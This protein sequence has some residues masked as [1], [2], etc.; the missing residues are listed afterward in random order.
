M[1]AVIALG[2]VLLG[3]FATW[4]VSTRVERRRERVQLGGVLGLL[5][6]ELAANSD[7][8][9]RGDD[10]TYGDWHAS[11]AA[12]SQLMRDEEL[13]RRVVKAYGTIFE[14]ARG[15]TPPPP[16]EE[17]DELAQVLAARRDRLLRRLRVVRLPPA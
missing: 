14:A 10:L 6:E 11:K 17:L 13:W 7:R 8:I 4:W 16:A 9:R 15:S 12:F 1:E 5:A 3:A 2:G